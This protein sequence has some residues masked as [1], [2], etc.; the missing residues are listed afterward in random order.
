MTQPPQNQPLPHTPREKVSVPDPDAVNSEFLRVG[1]EI[2][3]R[4][5]EAFKRLAQR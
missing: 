4:H 5:I 3:K 1:E 2:L